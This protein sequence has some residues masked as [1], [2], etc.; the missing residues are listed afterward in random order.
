LFTGS[1][2]LFYT[3]LFT[4]TF[5]VHVYG[6]L[7]LVYG[8]GLLGPFGCYLHTRFVYGYSYRFPFV[9]LPRSHGWVVH[10]R[11]VTLHT[12]VRVTF[13]HVYA[14]TG[15][16]RSRSTVRF[17]FTTH[18]CD[19]GTF[20]TTRLPTFTFT[21]TVYTRYGCLRLPFWVYVYS[22]PVATHVPGLRLRSTHTFTVHR[23]VA[24]TTGLFTF[25]VVT[26]T[27]LPGSVTF[28]RTVGWFPVRST[29]DFTF[30]FW[31]LVTV[32]LH[33]AFGL[34]FRLGSRGLHVT[35]RFTLPHGLRLDYTTLHYGY[36]TRLRY[37]FTHRL[38]TFT[39]LD[40]GFRL[41]LLRFHGYVTLH[42]VVTVYVYVTVVTRS[43]HT[44][45]VTLRVYTL[46]LVTVWFGYVYVVTVTVT[47]HRLDYTFD[48]YTFVGYVEL[49]V[50]LHVPVYGFTLHV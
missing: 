12:L 14:F 23:F 31:T 7:R 20:Y 5:T 34:L 22:S 49:P 1:V 18:V 25:T 29:F 10:T 41:R 38:F 47:L 46:R 26:V 13:T 30:T 19:F 32:G 2:R 3:R 24:F 44:F 36:Y 17:T 37:T 16:L 8:F 6:L 21:F 28:G 33:T 39:G 11:S 4:F 43:T 40:Y 35:V 27:R 15:W 42:T 48:V 50:R 45:T 9:G